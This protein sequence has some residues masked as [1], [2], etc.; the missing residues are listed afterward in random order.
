MGYKRAKDHWQTLDQEWPIF[1]PELKKWGS[2]GSPVD[3]DRI[4]QHLRLEEPEKLAKHHLIDLWNIYTD[5]YL[6]RFED[7]GKPLRPMPGGID[8]PERRDIVAD[9]GHRRS[10]EI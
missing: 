9:Q 7:R 1:I 6:P 5:Y 2:Y 3:Y 10:P 4:A 8:D